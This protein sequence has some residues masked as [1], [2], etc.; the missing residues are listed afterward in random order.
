MG[1]RCR[2]SWNDAWV[3]SV[4]NNNHKMPDVRPP[5]ERDSDK[6]P[7]VTEAVRS[8]ATT[9]FSRIATGQHAYGTRLPPERQMSEEFGTSRTTIRKALDMLQTFDVISRQQGR[10]RFITYR[11][12]RDDAK[13]T[14]TARGGQLARVGANEIAEI[15]SPLE[16][17]VVRTIIEPEIIRLATINMS[18]RDIAN[19]RRIVDE[20]A[21]V[22]TNAAEFAQ[23]DE[24][25]H[26]ALA[27]GTHNV[28]LIAIYRLI[29]DVRRHGHW[30]ATREKN[31]SPNR[32]RDY[33]KLYRSVCSALEARNMESAT[34][35]AKLIMVEAQRDLTFD[36]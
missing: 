23:L 29:N 21:A 15:T 12:A 31:L 16:L 9:L 7:F 2:R 4:N 25:F 19:L 34:E 26:L 36:T 8:I 3:P 20:L 18:A 11:A 28:L 32:I 13:Q 1:Y 5:W 14:E 6:H 10:S 22:T 24:Q 35:F 30:S 33:Q 17:N 27:E